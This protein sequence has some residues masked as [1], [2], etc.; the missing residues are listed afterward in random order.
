MLPLAIGGAAKTDSP[1]SVPLRLAAAHSRSDTEMTR[2][3][4]FPSNA[5]GAIIAS[6]SMPVTRGG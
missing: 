3:P 5:H 6:P 1:A 2:A 4:A